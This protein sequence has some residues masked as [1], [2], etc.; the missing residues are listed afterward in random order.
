M[1]MSG[2]PL[3]QHWSTAIQAGTDSVFS[4][5]VV[6]EHRGPMYHTDVDRSI[7]L[8]EAFSLERNDPKAIRKRLVNVL[9]GAFGEPFQAR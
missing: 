3:H 7:G 6:F 5:E 8:A 9:V 2:T 4:G 1:T